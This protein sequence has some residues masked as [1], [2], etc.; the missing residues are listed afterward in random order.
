MFLYKF[1]LDNNIIIFE[2]N[3][4]TINIYNEKTLSSLYSNTVTSLNNYIDLINNNNLFNKNGNNQDF[5]EM[6]IL[7]LLNVQIIYIKFIINGE[8]TNIYINIIRDDQDK[9][10]KLYRENIPNDPI[11]IENK[12][13]MYIIHNSELHNKY[14][15][16]VLHNLIFGNGQISIAY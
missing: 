4:D 2:Y 15:L 3:N 14:L 12:K 6:I 11:S 10:W 5:S 7:L 16:Y 8:T 1:K 13:T 9:L